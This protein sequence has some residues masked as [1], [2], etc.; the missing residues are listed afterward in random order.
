M[1]T[2]NDFC[3]QANVYMAAEVECAEQG[4]VKPPCSVCSNNASSQSAAC[5]AATHKCMDCDKLLCG[6][7]LHVHDALLPSHTLTSVNSLG[8]IKVTK[9]AHCSKHPAEILRFQCLSC[10]VP[11]CRDCRMT[12]HGEG[13]LCRDLSDMSCEARAVV[14]DITQLITGSLLPV[15]LSK[16]EFCAEILEERKASKESLQQAIKQREEELISIVKETAEQALKTLNE[17]MKVFEDDFVQSKSEVA[18]LRSQCDYNRLVIDGGCDAD[19]LLAVQ[20]LRSTFV[21]SSIHFETGTASSEQVIHWNKTEEMHFGDV[22]SDTGYFS[23]EDWKAFTE[24]YLGHVCLRKKKKSR[25][26]AHASFKPTVN[27]CL[28]K[29]EAALRAASSADSAMH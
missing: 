27:E 14:S 10:K 2:S 12:L 7:C 24:A 21:D 29:I 26:T 19:V 8:P 9:V 13:H 28:R 15:L 11:V 4:K 20:G 22:K 18:R 3:L 23:L 6:A 17:A 1:V 25:A 5:S 16:S